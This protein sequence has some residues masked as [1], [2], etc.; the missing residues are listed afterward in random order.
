MIYM[1][2]VVDFITYMTLGA[3]GDIY[4][5]MCILLCALCVYIY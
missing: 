1:D 3:L 2:I 5:E 4:E